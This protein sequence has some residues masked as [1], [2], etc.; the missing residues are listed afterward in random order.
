MSAAMPMLDPTYQ[1]SPVLRWAA[2]RL[3]LYG[4]KLVPIDREADP[5]SPIGAH[6]ATKTLYLPRGHSVDD[7]Y[8]WVGRG[9]LFLAGGAGWAPEF[10]GA[11]TPDY[12]YA[13]AGNVIP[14]PRHG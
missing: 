7:A 4:I 2:R 11:P 3:S 10:G 6:R 12:R 14:L 5:S 1:D 8:H 9:V 13:A